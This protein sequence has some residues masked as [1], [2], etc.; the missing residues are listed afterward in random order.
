MKTAVERLILL[1]LKAAGSRG[2]ANVE[3]ETGH[4]G[5]DQRDSEDAAE[6]A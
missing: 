3:A 6:A 4:A 2:R 5:D 1:M